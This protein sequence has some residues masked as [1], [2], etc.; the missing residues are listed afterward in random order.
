VQPVYS[1][2]IIEV[3]KK[4]VVG[5]GEGVS[6]LILKQD[7]GVRKI[8][9][10]SL[11]Y[12]QAAGNYTTLALTANRT[13]LQTRQLGTFDYLTEQDRNFCRVHRSILINLKKIRSL[14][15]NVI[16]FYDADKVL[17]VSSPLS[18]RIKKLLLGQ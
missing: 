14:K 13:M 4:Y 8:P 16:Q 5:T 6:E 9:L 11:L 2:G 17:E 10:N 18:L 7:D 1:D 12:L 3:Y 15:D